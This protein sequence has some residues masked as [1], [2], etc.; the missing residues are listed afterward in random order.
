MRL[1]LLLPSLALVGA[2]SGCATAVVLQPAELANDPA[3]A[4]VMVRLPDVVAGETRRSTN[5]QSTAAWGNPAA[6]ILRCGLPDPGPSALPCFTVDTIDWLRDDSGDPSF[7]FR[8]YGRAPGLEVIIDSTAVSGT[9]A[10]SD[11]AS[12]VGVLP[13]ERLCLDSTDVLGD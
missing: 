10:L 3:C 6:V 13:A 11:L 9:S 4:E 2:L 12:A 8:A 7:R 5:A 1:R